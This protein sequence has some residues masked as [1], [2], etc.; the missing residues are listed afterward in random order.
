MATHRCPKCGEEY[1]DTYRSCPFCEEEDA[2]K[3]GRPLRRRGGRRL[4]KRPSG[5]GGAGGIMLLLM[6][7]IILCVVLEIRLAVPQKIGHTQRNPILKKQM[8]KY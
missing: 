1:S 6:C 7:V 3:H 4:E 8:E 2:I 5:S